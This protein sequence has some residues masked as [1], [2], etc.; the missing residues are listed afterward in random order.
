[1]SWVAFGSFPY[2]PLCEF[3]DPKA[4]CP[5]PAQNKLENEAHPYVWFPPNSSHIDNNYL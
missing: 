5:L 1:M 2:S 4:V 3:I